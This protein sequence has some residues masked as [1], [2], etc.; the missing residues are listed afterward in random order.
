MPRESAMRLPPACTVP[1]RFS[2][3]LPL[4]LL[5]LWAAAVLGAGGCDGG[6]QAGR[7][8]QHPQDT[9][10][11]GAHAGPARTGGSP[12]PAAP[13]RGGPIV[14]GWPAEPLAVNELIAP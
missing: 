4:L 12:A 6:H 9:E 11:R 5:S 3:R 8:A 1:G 7:P 10:G 13:R 2:A 14:T